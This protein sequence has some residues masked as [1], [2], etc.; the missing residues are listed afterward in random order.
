MRNKLIVIVSV[1]GIALA[2]YS[3]FVFSKSPPK[4]TPVFNP[5]P[6]PYADGIFANGIIES[7]QT[8]GENINIYPEVSGPITGM[9]VAEGDHV[10]AGA[11]LMTIDESVQRATARQLR[12]QADAAMTQLN[13]LKAQPRPETLA[14][15]TAQMEYAKAQLKS[16]TDTLDKD[17]RTYTTD[18]GSI[19]MDLLDTARNNARAAQMNLTVAQKQLDLTSAGAWSYDIASQQKQYE[20]LCSA[21][22]ASEALLNK[23]TI[24]A[25]IDGIV[26]SIQASRGSYVSSQG[27]YD[28]YTSGFDPLVVMGSEQGRL[29]V[30]CYVD[31]I[32]VHRLPESSAMT[33]TMY[34]RGTDKSIPLTFQ[35]MQP[36]VSPKIE[37]SDQRTERVDVRVLPVIFQFEKPTDISLYPGQLVDVFIGRK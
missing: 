28:T 4:Q 9:A 16:A 31:E 37:L 25:P 20:A 7:W 5:S 36:Y 34:I 1:L 21:A 17:E 8:N 15:A 22:T 18:P 29:E 11:V 6:N 13:E 23:Y 27:V 14:V 26:F 30:R 19:S 2:V 32:L 3:A 33:A 24:R 12:S 35:R 10:K